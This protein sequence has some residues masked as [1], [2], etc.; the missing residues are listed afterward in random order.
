MCVNAIH[1]MSLMLIRYRNYL[2]VLVIAL[3]ALAARPAHALQ[4]PQDWKVEQRDGAEIFSPTDLREGEILQ[5][6]IYPHSPFQAEGLEAWLKQLAGNDAPPPGGKWSEA[7]SVTPKAEQLMTGARAW[8][9]ARGQRGTVIYTATSL[10]GQ[11]ARLVRFTANASPALQRH[12]QAAQALMSAAATEKPSVSATHAPPTPAAG[13]SPPSPPPQAPGASEPAPDAG[14]PAATPKARTDT[15]TAPGAETQPPARAVNQQATAEGPSE[16]QSPAGWTRV[17]GEGAEIHQPQDLQAGEIMQVAFYPRASMGADSNLEVWLRKV[18]TKDMPPEGKWSGEVQAERATDNVVMGSR[19]WRDAHGAL[20]LA[21]YS[22]V[23]LDGLSVRMARLLD[24]GSPASQR[25]RQAAKALIAQMAAAETRAASAAGRATKIEA[26]PPPVKGIQPGGPIVPGL[27]SGNYIADRRDVLYRLDVML[28]ANG[29]YDFIGRRDSAGTIR[30]SETT[31][32]LDLKD[33]LWNNIYNPKEVFCI[34]GRNAK[35]EPVIHHEDLYC[36][37][38]YRIELRR[39]GDV[40]RDPPSVAKQKQEAEHAEAA[41]YKFVTEPGKGIAAKD[42][43]ALAY[44]WEQVSVVGG[45]E[46]CY[47]AYLLLKDGSVHNG[48][49][50]PP[51]DMNVADSKKYDANRWGRWRKNG[52]GYEFAWGKGDGFK[53]MSRLNVVSPAQTNQRL[54]GTWG[55]S[56]SVSTGGGGSWSFWG[57]TLN[58]DGRFEKY[59]RGGHGASNPAAEVAAGVVYDDEGSSS[60]VSGP[61]VGGGASSKSNKTKAVRSGTYSLNG[62]TMELRY[63]NGTVVRLPFFLS[64]K[65]NPSIWFEGDMLMQEKPDKK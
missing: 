52:S 43:E 19:H 49:P 32:K 48:L 5:V 46:M 11:N 17:A 25:H 57:V 65:D 12:R 18:M 29:E 14:E 24:S 3:A 7:L 58:S 64:G 37:G 1:K 56:W 42:I 60:T 50:V 26:L 36:C 10:D 59:R 41:R 4:P 9:D 6:A 27:Y 51:Q 55:T 28:F 34:Y 44:R 38:G 33:P 61:N 39:V 8:S 47:Y 2:F 63:G 30:Y 62:Y 22:A 21:M 53:Q 40:D 31:G 13:S 23:T 15:A 16:F 20:S 45:L 54:Q 35:G